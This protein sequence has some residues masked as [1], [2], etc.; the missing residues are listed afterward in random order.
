MFG[1]TNNQILPLISFDLYL[2]HYHQLIKTL[3]KEIDLEQIHNFLKRHTEGQFQELIKQENY[4]AIVITTLDQHIVWVSDGFADMTGYQKN[5]ALGKKPSF[6]QGGSTSNK[7]KQQIKEQL[8]SSHNYKGSIVNYKKNGDAYRC[9]I[10]IVPL[11]NSKKEL[12]H[13]MALE[14]ELKVA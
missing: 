8:Q 9:Q 10:K 3:K 7:T 12:T 6:L 11:Y 1:T 4:D 13:F 14:K 5:Y 2:E